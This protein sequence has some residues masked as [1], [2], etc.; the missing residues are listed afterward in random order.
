MSAFCQCGCGQQ[1]PLAKQ[2]D[3]RLGYVKGQ[4]VRFI[5]GHGTRTRRRIIDDFWSYVGPPAATGCREWQG[6]IG[7]KGYGRVG[8]GGKA[9]RAAWELTNGPIP[10]GLCVLHR[11]DNP[12]CCEPAHLFLGTKADNN[13]DMYAKGRANPYDRHGERNPANKLSDAQ[14]V[15]IVRRY[16]SG[17]ALQQQLA[18]EYGVTQTRVSQIVRRPA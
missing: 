1:A 17:E 6:A 5:Q 2:T 4:P 14:R 7:I 9:H 12:P 10:D 8:G 16:R 18:D 15:E 13:R 11:C 3:N